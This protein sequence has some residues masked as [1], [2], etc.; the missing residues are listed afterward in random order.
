MVWCCVTCVASWIMDHAEHWRPRGSLR[1][2]RADMLMCASQECLSPASTVRSRIR[3]DLS[4]VGSQPA[5]QL[6]RDRLIVHSAPNALRTSCALASSWVV[7]LAQPL[8]MNRHSNTS[9][10]LRSCAAAKL[11]LLGST[12]AMRSSSTPIQPASAC[13]MASHGEVGISRPER[14]MLRLPSTLSDAG[15][16]PCIRPPRTAPPAVQWLPPQPCAKDARVTADE[17]ADVSRG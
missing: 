13:Q 15:K 17:R 5:P 8:G 11:S 9:A 16:A 6:Y 1:A 14:P 3:L 7:L 10:V 12:A 2:G 4:I